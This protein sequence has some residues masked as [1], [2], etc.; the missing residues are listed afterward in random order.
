MVTFSL[1]TAGFPFIGGVKQRRDKDQYQNSLKP[2]KYLR[3]M[4]LFI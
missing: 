2:N 4:L 3:K 1:L